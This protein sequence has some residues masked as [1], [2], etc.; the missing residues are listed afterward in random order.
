MARKVDKKYC[1]IQGDTKGPILRTLESFGDVQGLV[2]GAFGEGS[3]Q[4]HRLASTLAEI[5]SHMHY[6]TMHVAEPAGQ[7]GSGA[8]HPKRLGLGSGEGQCTHHPGQPQQGGQQCER[9]KQAQRR[10]SNSGPM[11]LQTHKPCLTRSAVC[12]AATPG[13]AI[14]LASPHEYS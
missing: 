9:S 10:W 2:W 13:G 4:C 7:I 6:K 1:G 14:R 11:R 12:G 3:I 5:G 8:S